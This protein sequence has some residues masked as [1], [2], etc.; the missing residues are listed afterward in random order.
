ML[1]V[2]KK[3]CGRQFSCAGWWVRMSVANSAMES[4]SRVCQHIDTPHRILVTGAGGFIGRA[5]V[6]Q[7]L[8]RGWK[9]RAMLRAA[10]VG[11]WPADQN[12]E[13]VDADIRNRA[14]LA[15]AVGGTDV[16][17]HLAAAKSDE[18]W[19]E[20]VNV[21]GAQHLVD[22]CRA[23]GCHRL[24]NVSTQSVKI[25]R[26]GT[27]GRTKSQADKIFDE[28]GLAVTTLLPSIVYGE[29]MAGVFGTVAQMIRKLPVVP[30]LGD[31]CWVSAP[32]YVG[33]VA[34]A[35]CR[36]I[37]LDHSI[38][39][40]YDIG[41]PDLMSFDELIDRV[42]LHIGIKRRKF[43]I[44]FEIALLAARTLSAL[45]AN[46]P[47]TVSN[48]LGS[49][50]DTHIDINSAR[51]DF[52][53]EPIDFATG[54][55]LTEVPSAWGAGRIG[56]PTDAELTDECKL[57]TR[58]LIDESPPDE[59]IARYVAANR[60]LFAGTPRRRDELA[61]VTRHP[62]AL[63]FLDAAAGFFHPESPLRSSLLLMTA[64]LETTPLY[65]DYFLGSQ[66]TPVRL[67]GTLIWSGTCAAAKA[68]LG[69]PILWIATRS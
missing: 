37:E 65:S 48:V 20:D 34:E 28:S 30:I 35:I 32:V 29:Q 24:I 33:D 31:G 36:S 6:A 41:G 57:L 53:W 12:L 26:K 49:N 58:Y 44:P 61:F 46:P 14:A 9:V 5:V 56:A 68:A 47:I 67:C 13:L 64:I 3:V 39:K 40:K 18:K 38:G 1:P 7:L 4:V 50:Q 2:V 21:G 23:A 8:R 52:A 45:T 42:A 54:I 19:S 63:P 15:K 51:N 60:I 55:R 16:V 66:Q 59:L 11:L 27:Y 62:S 25:A 10:A 43:H 22:A 69:I 17:V